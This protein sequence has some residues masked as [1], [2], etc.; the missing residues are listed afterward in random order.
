VSKYKYETE[1]YQLFRFHL[2]YFLN[3]VPTGLKYKNRL[4]SIIESNKISKRAKKLEIKK[5]L[6][7]MTSSDLAKTFNELL[8]K[9]K[10]DEQLGGRNRRS[11]SRDEK[12]S[13]ATERYYRNKAEDVLLFEA[14]T[15]VQIAPPGT[16]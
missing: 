12:P 10:I 1:L 16:N 5:L 3:F 14:N 7:Q 4:E 13:M 6:Y 9:K 8:K 2:S 15:P 11:H